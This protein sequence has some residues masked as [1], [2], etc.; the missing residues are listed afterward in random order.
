MKVG[1]YTA[2][3]N[4]STLPSVRSQEETVR[5]H[6]TKM[7]QKHLPSSHS[8]NSETGQD[9][10]YNVV[11]DRF[12]ISEEEVNINFEN[13]LQ[14]RVGLSSLLEQMCNDKVDILSMYN[15]HVLSSYPNT[16]VFLTNE[17]SRRYNISTIFV[18]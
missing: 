16:L 13:M 15:P 12:N 4:N 8:P 14:E 5:N 18:K 17:I 11:S 7:M 2:T 10:I 1:I 3:Y 9:C 6:L